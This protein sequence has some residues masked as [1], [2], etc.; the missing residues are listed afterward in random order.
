MNKNVSLATLIIK[1]FSQLKNLK[2]ID[3]APNLKN[4]YRGDAVWT[5]AI[6]DSLSLLEN[7]SI[8][9]LGFYFKKIENPSIQPLIEMKN[10]KQLYCHPSSFE[11]EECAR[12]T[13][14]R[15]DVKGWLSQPYFD[16]GNGYIM[17]VGKRKPL[18]ALPI[19]EKRL[20]SYEERWNKL[21][22]KYKPN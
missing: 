15:P 11:T 2:N 19:D 21:V 14:F 22:D 9:N 3:T 5:K 8:E 17:V 7:S 12:F 4:F 10:L 20:K 16:W 18:L 1:D 6:T 13:A